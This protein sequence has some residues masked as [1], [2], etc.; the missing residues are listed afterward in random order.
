[1]RSHPAETDPESCSSRSRNNGPGL[2]DEGSGL[3]PD[4][5]DDGT[6]VMQGQALLGPLVDAEVR[7]YN[8]EKFDGEDLGLDYE[9]DIEPDCEV[10]STN[11]D[12][13]DE[14]GLILLPNE[15]IKDDQIY[16][17]EVTGGLDIDVDDD[18][19]LDAVPSAQA[20]DIHMVVVGGRLLDRTW[21]VTRVTDATFRMIQE[22]FLLDSTPEECRQRID[23][24]A[25]TLVGDVT[26]DGLIDRDDIF[27]WNPLEHQH[28]VNHDLLGG[29]SED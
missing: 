23:E 2:I 1:M 4:L 3:G 19:V 8:L 29:I 18:G 21:K 22:D 28:L 27:E 16:F 9:H 17:L 5:T 26:G 13:L 10:I 25:P 12:V 15:C 24:F 7:V 14:A 11:S 20:F 6:G